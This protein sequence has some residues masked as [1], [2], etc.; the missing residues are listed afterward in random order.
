[1]A[2]MLD[3]PLYILTVDPL[4]YDAFDAERSGYIEEWKNLADELEVEALLVCI[5]RI[6][7]F[8]LSK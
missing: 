6:T 7:L 4:P 1:M 3:C 2:S 5:V 8:L